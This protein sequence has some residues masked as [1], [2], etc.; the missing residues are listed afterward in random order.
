MAPSRTAALFGVLLGFVLT[1]CGSDPSESDG[2]LV[3]SSRAATPTVPTTPTDVPTTGVPTDQ[4]AAAAEEALRKYLTAYRTGNA[5]LA[6]ELSHPAY[7]DAVVQ[8]SSGQTGLPKNPTC[9]DVY[10]W[11][12]DFIAN[13]PSVLQPHGLTVT[14]SG[15]KATAKATFSGREF[16]YYLTYV[17]GRWLVSGDGDEGYLG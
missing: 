2:P 6:C 17:D 11:A 5:R 7:A 16:T 8:T 14:V 10:R 13:D 4:S 3:S 1:S 9:E 12:H 15:D